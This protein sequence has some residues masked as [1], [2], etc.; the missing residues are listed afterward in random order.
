MLYFPFG[1]PVSRRA[2]ARAG[3]PCLPS[4]RSS[5]RLVSPA[6]GVAVAAGFF[7]LLA[8]VPG[9][10]ANSAP[11][12]TDVQATQIGGTGTVRITCDVSDADGDQVTARVVCSSN[13]GT[14]FDLLPVTLSGDV[15]VTMAPGP[16][17]QIAGT[18]PGA[19]RRTAFAAT[20]WASAPRP[21]S[22]ALRAPRSSLPAPPGARAAAAAPAP[23]SPR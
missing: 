15:N 16:G 12:V 17:K 14:T 21:L 13:D 23:P 10:Q 4:R 11:V 7:L 9:V 22:W 3:S 20:A 5:M 19:S 6:H 18:A 8:V 2:F 1:L